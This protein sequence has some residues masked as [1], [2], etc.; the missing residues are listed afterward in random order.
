MIVKKKAYVALLT[1]LT[2]LIMILSPISHPV[3]ATTGGTV[4]LEDRQEV[5]PNFKRTP[6]RKSSRAPSRSASYYRILST[7]IRDK[8]SGLSIPDVDLTVKR[9]GE[10]LHFKLKNGGFVAQNGYTFNFE[11]GVDYTLDLHKAGYQPITGIRLRYDHNRSAWKFLNALMHPAPT[12]T[13]A[14]G[15][16]DKASM[17]YIYGS[18]VT[19]DGPSGRMSRTTA[20]GS[21]VA[22]FYHLPLGKYTYAIQAP[23]YETLSGHLTLNRSNNQVLVKYLKPGASQLQVRVS[24]QDGPVPG[25]IV[26]A[27]ADGK[28]WTEAKTDSAGIATL[29]LST[30]NYVIVASAKDHQ[31]PAKPTVTLPHSGIV[32]VKLKKLTPKLRVR[33]TNERGPVNRAMVRAAAKAKQP[34]TAYT[35]S[36]GYAHLKLPNGDYSLSV[37]APNH[38]VEPQPDV[39]MPH[40]GTLE[41]KLTYLRPNTAT[42]SFNILEAESNA[43]LQG[44]QVSL[45]GPGGQRQGATKYNTAYATFGNLPMGTYRYWVRKQGYQSATG[46]IQVKQAKAISHAVRLKR[47]ADPKVKIGELRLKVQSTKNHVVKNA[48]VMITGQNQNNFTKNARSNSLGTAEFYRVPVGKY[49]CTVNHRDY[50]KKS[51]AITVNQKMTERTITLSLK[52]NNYLQVKVVDKN[53]KAVTGARV[54]ISY[55]KKVAFRSVTKQATLMTDASGMAK[56]NIKPYRAV[57]IIAS[58]PGHIQGQWFHRNGIDVPDVVNVRLF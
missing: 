45:N 58:K 5:P 33:V 31:T 46:I 38:V 3:Q 43:S 47:L 13:I 1:V 26:R 34:V 12:G 53:G 42:L 23:N 17:Q 55:K 6:P 37:Y 10:T 56:L 11:A 35:N 54:V 44:V 29:S 19:I 41:L 25:A 39:T 51:M 28:G 50:E 7:Q 48:S 40:S 36:A 20:K 21:E 49:T 14:I 4:K 9:P 27:G 22:T 30:G 8:Y 18:T 16:M 32:Q 57:K 24:N 52:K 15:P 2:A